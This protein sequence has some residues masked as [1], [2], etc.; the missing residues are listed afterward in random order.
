MLHTVNILYREKDSVHTYDDV[1][2]HPHLGELI[3]TIIHLNRSRDRRDN[4]D[5][6]TN[7]TEINLSGY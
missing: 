6:L 4:E 7:K 3:E 2:I 1:T 5:N